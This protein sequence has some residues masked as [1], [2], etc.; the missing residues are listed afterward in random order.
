MRLSQDEIKKAF[1]IWN[2][3][4]HFR[5]SDQRISSF[6]S[7][8]MKP[9]S[10]SSDWLRTARLSLFF[11]KQT[12][13][14]KLNITV[15]AYSNFE[16]NEINGN[17]SMNSLAKAA[18]AMDCELVYAI[19][20]K[21]K[22]SF[23]ILIWRQILPHAVKHPWIQKCDPKKKSEALAAIATRTM[24]DSEFRREHGWSKRKHVRS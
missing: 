13:A 7:S 22:V 5:D 24:M 3:R 8:E 14:Q 20:P 9:F 10:K 17:I 23:S 2:Y 18:E 4:N 11:S 15:R 1:F 16:D 6:L 12:I 21:E 19:R